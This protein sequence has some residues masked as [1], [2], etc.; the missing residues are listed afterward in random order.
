M[1]L[2]HDRSLGRT[3]VT[4]ERNRPKGATELP[5]VP[6]GIWSH[7]L[8]IDIIGKVLRNFPSPSK[9]KMTTPQPSRE[10]YEISPRF[11]RVLQDRAQSLENDAQKDEAFAASL[12]NPGHRHR[13]QLLIQA[14]R[15]KARRLWDFLAGARASAG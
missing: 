13:H 2:H 11:Y 7:F 9:E 14:Q 8:C 6:L 4:T 1:A 15:D 3:R 5:E 12:E 10:L